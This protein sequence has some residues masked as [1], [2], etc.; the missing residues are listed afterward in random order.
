MLQSCAVSR[1]PSKEGFLKAEIFFHFCSFPFFLSKNFLF[2]FSL[3]SFHGYEAYMWIFLIVDEPLSR[4]NFL[5]ALAVNK[6]NSQDKTELE[7]IIFE[8]LRNFF[9]SKKKYLLS[10]IFA[11]SPSMRRN[12]FKI[13]PFCVHFE[14][15][16][17]FLLNYYDA[18]TNK[19][20][21]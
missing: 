9:L 18:H 21:R 14:S 8:K 16:H 4:R 3:R 20:R 15:R 2:F 1:S 7:M 11:A 6:K 12:K 17:S 19:V 5:S 13:P 10:T